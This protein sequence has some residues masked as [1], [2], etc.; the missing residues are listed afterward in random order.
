MRYLKTIIKL[1]AD[2]VVGS[3]IGIVGEGWDIFTVTGIDRDE[4]GNVTHVHN[5]SG[6]REP[7]SKIYLLRGRCHSE[8]FDDPTSW[9]DV[10]FGECDVCGKKFADCCVYQSDKSNPNSML[11]LKCAGML[12]N[13]KVRT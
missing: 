9:V 13:V 12:T 11:C 3:E 2:M 8:A 7:L 10:R 4:S 6:W 1:P 5:S